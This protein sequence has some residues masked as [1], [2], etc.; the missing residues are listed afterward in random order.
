MFGGEQRPEPIPKA[1]LVEPGAQVED[2]DA[3][4]TVPGRAVAAP[5]DSVC[6]NAGIGATVRALAV[7]EI[8]GELVL[9][10]LEDVSRPEV[11]L[12]LDDERANLD[13]DASPIR[14]R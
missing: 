9:G 7:D 14:R 3:L 4:D 8:A 1:P 11:A 12:A 5:G 2:G 10:I 13:I 6:E